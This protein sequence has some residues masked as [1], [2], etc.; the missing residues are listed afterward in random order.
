MRIVSSVVSERMTIQVEPTAQKIKVQTTDPQIGM[1]Q[2]VQ[3]DGALGQPSISSIE[4]PNTA[5]PCVYSEQRRSRARRV[6]RLVTPSHGVSVGEIHPRDGVCGPV[7]LI[8]Y[9]G[10]AAV[11][12]GSTMWAMNGVTSP[13]YHLLTRTALKSIL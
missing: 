9:R 13:V 11:S 12:S 7:L 10:I 6:P 8:L 5:K 2:E 3:G 4:N 1:K